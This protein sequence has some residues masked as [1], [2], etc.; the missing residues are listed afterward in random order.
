M[1]VLCPVR[2]GG[3]DGSGEGA[4]DGERNDGDQNLKLS[5]MLDLDGKRTNFFFWPDMLGGC[6]QVFRGMIDDC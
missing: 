3:R 6:K 4:R 5:R 1:C 2:E